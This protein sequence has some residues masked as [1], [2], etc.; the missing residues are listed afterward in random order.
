MKIFLLSLLTLALLVY[1]YFELAYIGFPDGHITDYDNYRY[2]LLIV[3]N[4]INLL[5]TGISILY[6][7]NINIALA[8][9]I[10]I[11]FC[12]TYANTALSNFSGRGG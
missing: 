1:Y 12:A 6:K 7:K 11:N 3:I 8:F 2:Y 5:L 10:I 4:L 9:F